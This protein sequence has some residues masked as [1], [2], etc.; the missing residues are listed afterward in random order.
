MSLPQSQ[1]RSGPAITVVPAAVPRV[2]LAVPPAA[3]PLGAARR[4][5]RRNSAV[6]TL[7]VSDAVTTTAVLTA[8]AWLSPA[9]HHHFGRQAA[10]VAVT[11][12]A[13]A[14]SFAAKGIY[15]RA[16]RHIVPAPADDLTALTAALLTAAL[17]TLAAR[18]LLPGALGPPLPAS[19]VLAGLAGCA[20]LLPAARALALAVRDRMGKESTRVLVV[21][22]GTIAADVGG[23]LVR[24]SHVELVGY[25]D[26]DPVEGHD[27]I[28]GLD[29]LP[30]IC[31]RRRI[32]RVV[33]AF[34]RAHPRR[35]AD[36]LRTLDGTVTVDIVPRYFELTGWEAVVDDLSGLALVSLGGPPSA[37]SLAVKRGLDVLGAS[38]ALLVLSPVLVVVAAMV[39]ATS[40]GPVLFRQLRVGRDGA[41]FGILK[42]RTMREPTAEE[43]AQR[44]RRSG[45]DLLLDA[46]K[47][48]QRTTQVGRLL[49]RSGLDELPQLLNVLLGHMSL[50]GPRPLVPDECADLPGWAEKRFAFRPGVTGMWQVSGQHDLRLDELCRLDCQYVNTWTLL[51]DLRILARTP[52]RLLRGGTVEQKVSGPATGPPGPVG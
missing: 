50:V 32:D 36:V 19:S 5:P 23:R 1:G 29:A 8:T 24:S 35:L 44:G 30:A 37:L 43:V 21:G 12:A 40:A 31:E 11:W 48:G 15:L 25:V 22:T 27:V 47:D 52:E 18:S 49:R 39:K 6:G 38:F 42:F 10:F 26:D 16:R 45:V 41:T 14:I 17:V 28:G 7:L 2:A 46:G 9:L 34:S 20:V 51:D 4:R 3:D 13:A 33:V